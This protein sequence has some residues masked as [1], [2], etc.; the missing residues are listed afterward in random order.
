MISSLI[1]FS[2]LLLTASYSISAEEIQIVK[3]PIDDVMD[4]TIEDLDEIPTTDEKPNIDVISLTYSRNNQSNKATVIL[5]V[6][7]RGFIEDKGSLDFESGINVVYSMQ[8]ET[9]QDYYDIYYINKVCTVNDETENILWDVGGS[10]LTIS[11]DLV[12][13][14]ETYVSLSAQTFELNLATFGMYADY[15]PNIDFL[16]VIV[17]APSD[18]TAGQSIKFSAS[19]TG[20][21]DPY[22]WSWDFDDG[23]FS[24]VQNPTHVYTEPGT[25]NVTLLVTDANENI[26]MENHAVEVTGKTDDNGEIN[27]NNNGQDNQSSDSGLI[28]FI[29]VIAIIVIIGVVI[30]IRII[31]R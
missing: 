27:G 22:N 8:L 6:N 23:N 20:G 28:L 14:E 19:V 16:E 13:A 30:L 15:I 24:Y 18:V 10:K 4:L 12:S 7:S 3:D 1:V 29:A 25:Y 17:N 31:R 9:S 26:G 5:E 11:F 2:I 21:T